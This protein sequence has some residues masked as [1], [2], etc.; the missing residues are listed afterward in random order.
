MIWDLRGQAFGKCAVLSWPQGTQVSHCSLWKQ[1]CCVLLW[2]AVEAANEPLSPFPG[3]L[4][5]IVATLVLVF[6][7][8]RAVV[9]GASDSVAAIQSALM[10]ETW[11][12]F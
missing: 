2:L 11:R 6:S 4:G 3:L 7:V 1:R 8:L 10:L 12:D 9:L 5:S